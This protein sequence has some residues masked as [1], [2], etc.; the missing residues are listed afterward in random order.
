MNPRENDHDG[1]SQTFLN[2]AYRHVLGLGENY[3]GRRVQIEYCIKVGSD[4]FLSMYRYFH[5]AQTELLPS[6]F[7]RGILGGIVRD[8]SYTDRST[9]QGYKDH[10]SPRLQS[11]WGNEFEGIH[12]YMSGELYILS[13]DLVEFVLKEVPFSRQRIAPGGYVTGEEGYD[14]S[15]MVFHSPTPLHI[16]TIGKSQRFWTH[17]V[18]SNA[19]WELLVAVERQLTSKRAH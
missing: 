13:C 11:F 5:F 7:H 8:K 3:D 9:T 6:P 19:D 12:L 10:D 15:S 1:K 14:I 16:I 18:Q 2:F 4:T 17:P